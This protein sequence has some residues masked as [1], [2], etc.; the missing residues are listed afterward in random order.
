MPTARAALPPRRLRPPPTTAQSHAPP[1][2]P[3]MLTAYA[4]ALPGPTHHR[5]LASHRCQPPDRLTA[6]YRRPPLVAARHHRPSLL[7]D[8]NCKNFVLLPK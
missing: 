4:A 2:A 3:P 8:Q 5:P 6:T 7:I 1:P